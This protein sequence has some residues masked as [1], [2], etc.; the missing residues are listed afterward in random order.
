MAVFKSIIFCFL[1]KKEVKHNKTKT[2]K[3]II[4]INYTFSVFLLC[5]LCKIIFFWKILTLRIK[6]FIFLFP[7]NWPCIF[8][9]VF[10][11]DQK[12]YLV[13][14]VLFL[15]FCAQFY[16]LKKLEHTILSSHF[17][18]FQNSLI[19]LFTSKGSCFITK[20]YK[21]LFCRK[22]KKGFSTTNTFFSG[23]RM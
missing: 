9:A 1:K 19:D 22:R 10:P 8:F 11:V 20:E 17:C 21:M 14:P 5:L 6:Q 18:L 15:E 23:L 4:I 7:T 13:S 3:P 12:I 2:K 16:F